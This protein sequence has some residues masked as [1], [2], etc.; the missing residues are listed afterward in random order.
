MLK[1]ISKIGI[2]KAKICKFFELI[3]GK[4]MVP[5]GNEGKM[6]YYRRTCSSKV[7]LFSLYLCFLVTSSA[8]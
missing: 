1:Y 5:T 4:D 3:G 8:S 6:F 7:S 2:K